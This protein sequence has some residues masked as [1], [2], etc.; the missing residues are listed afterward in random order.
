MIK[1]IKY[2]MYGINYLIQTKIFRREIPFIGGLVINEKCNLKCKHCKV[3]NREIP[4]LSYKN[5][6]R[7]LKIFFDKGIRSVFVEGGEPYSLLWQG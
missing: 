5:I 1:K 6:E 4:D 3:S 2:L 7:G